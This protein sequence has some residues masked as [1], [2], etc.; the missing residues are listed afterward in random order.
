MVR[1]KKKKKRGQGQSAT[2]PSSSANK[3][4]ELA[5]PQASSKFQGK[6]NQGIQG[7]QGSSGS[8][9]SQT[10][11][12]FQVIDSDDNGSEYE[13]GEVVD[14]RSRVTRS[15]IPASTST[16][17][18]SYQSGPPIIPPLPCRHL[19]NC[20]THLSI[21]ILPLH[22]KGL[23]EDCQLGNTLPSLGSFRKATAQYQTPVLDRDVSSSLAA[24]LVVLKVSSLFWIPEFTHRDKPRKN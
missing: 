1:S 23:N 10:T 8:G 9:A 20:P 2:F 22:L 21:G 4:S 13:E 5:R 18:S 14:D 16:I 15:A 6:G 12:V 17:V 24:D 19:L 3:V 7:D 11:R